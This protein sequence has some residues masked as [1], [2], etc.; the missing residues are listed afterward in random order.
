MNA[1]VQTGEVASI[2]DEIIA[3]VAKHREME[4]D[5]W[6]AESTLED[7]G[8]DSFDFIELVFMLEDKYGIE[9]DYNANQTVNELKT[10]GDVALK[11]H[12]L[13]VAKVPA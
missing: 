7:L 11:V 13:I 1:F 4:P 12:Q 8:V 10:I 3:I 6:T 2:V 9:I 5:G